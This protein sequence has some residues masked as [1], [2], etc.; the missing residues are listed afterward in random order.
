MIFHRLRQNPRLRISY[1]V[2]NHSNKNETAENVIRFLLKQVVAQLPKAPKDVYEEYCRYKNDT[3]K[4]EL[5]MPKLKGMLKYSLD[6]L[7]KSASS[8]SCILLDAYDEFRNLN[9]NAEER[10]RDELRKCLSEI[11]HSNSAKI[12]ITTRPHCTS[13]LERDFVGQ[14]VAECKG[15]LADMEKY[16][17]HELEVRRDLTPKL[18]ALI[19]TTILE[20]VNNKEPL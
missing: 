4:V 11:S 8:P 18:K 9:N 14:Q 16:L 1:F 20:A 2:F 6:E 17:D 19:Q 5:E 3:H 10:E 12:F 7:F 13:E 15:D